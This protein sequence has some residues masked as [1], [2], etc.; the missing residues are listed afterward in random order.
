MDRKQFSSVLDEAV[1]KLESDVRILKNQ[2]LTVAANLKT[3]E[4]TRNKLSKSIF[5][6]EAEFKAKKAEFADEIEKTNAI[7]ADK[8]KKA[9]EKDS[10]AS[11]NLS[12]LNNKIREADNLIK[13]NQ[14]LQK[15][16]NFQAADLKN[17]L[18]SFKNIE[19]LIKEILASL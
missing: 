14:N 9:N 13:S 12:E 18:E 16:L 11:V 1:G 19:T 17:K 2:Q 8:L 7:V 6:L 10:L 15:N 5:D 3:L 4:E